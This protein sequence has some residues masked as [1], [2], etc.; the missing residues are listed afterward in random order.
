MQGVAWLPDGHLH[1]HMPL[2]R[3]T[4]DS[5]ELCRFV[6]VFASNLQPMPEQY[7]DDMGPFGLHVNPQISDPELLFPKGH[8]KLGLK[9]TV[10][11]KRLLVFNIENGGL[12]PH[13]SPIPNNVVVSIF[14][15]IPSL[16][17]IKQQVNPQP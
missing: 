14:V 13:N 3:G 15:S 9:W 10:H 1:G 8:A 5:Q 2:H 17:V 6:S 16:L 4:E 11:S 7:S 12:D